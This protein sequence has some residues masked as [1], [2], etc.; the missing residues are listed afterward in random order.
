M[1]EKQQP[2]VDAKKS[3]ELLKK[4]LSRSIESMTDEEALQH[5]GSLVDLGADMQSS[6]I[7]DRALQLLTE[8]DARDLSNVTLRSKIDGEAGAF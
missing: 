2:T 8:L 3:E 6:E 1:D 5:V 4:L 7:T